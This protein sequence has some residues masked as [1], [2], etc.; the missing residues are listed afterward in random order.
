MVTRQ[1]AGDED[2]R[3]VG[4]APAA[5]LTATILVAEDDDTIRL[6]VHRVLERHGYRV[7]AA[8]DGDAAWSILLD[9][10]AAVDL[11]IVDAVMPRA[12]GQGLLLAALARLAPA[13][14]FL[15]ISAWGQPWVA[16]IVRELLG[17]APLLA[18]GWTAEELVGQ[19]QAVL[20]R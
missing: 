13:V 11:V 12:A 1:S 3:P 20:A 10:N 15:V 5:A 17:R 9:P 8:A 16:R 7:L 6:A 18:K 2:R 14:Q 19:V 4:T